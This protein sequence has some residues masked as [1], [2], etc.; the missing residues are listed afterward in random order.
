MPHVEATQHHAHADTADTHTRI[1][2]VVIFYTARVLYYM[3]LV[4]IERTPRDHCRDCRRFGLL[5]LSFSLSLF[6]LQT[7]VCVCVRYKL[8]T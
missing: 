5:S 6:V 8:A 2:E 4:A 3:Y 7:R 1:H